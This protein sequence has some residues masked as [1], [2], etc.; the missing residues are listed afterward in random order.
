M[1]CWGG[2]RDSVCRGELQWIEAVDVYSSDLSAFGVG[3]GD[4][5][6]WAGLSPL[7]KNRLGICADFPGGA[8]AD[9]WVCAL[10]LERSGGGESI[11][12][13]SIGFVVFGVAGG[14]S[15]SKLFMAGIFPGVWLALALVVTWWWLVRK[16]AVTPPPKKSSQEVLEALRLAAWALVLPLIIVFGLKFGIFTPTEAAVVA[17]VYSLF[18]S[19]VLIS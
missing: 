9:A 4:L 14:V 8:R 11:I 18:V 17:A 10:C 5:V 3:T 13:P 15:I 16:E 6:E 1:G 7:R 19:T 12:P 2:D